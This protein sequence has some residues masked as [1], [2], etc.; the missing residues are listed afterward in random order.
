MSFKEKVQ[1]FL[2]NNLSVGRLLPIMMTLIIVWLLSMTWG[3]WTSIYSLI[4]GIFLPF[5]L[6]FALAY[7]LRPAV[8]FFERYH[9]KRPLAVMI[10][11][12]IF[13]A[14]LALLFSMIIPAL[15]DDIS[16]FINSISENI[17]I[18]YDRYVEM[19]DNPSQLVENLITQFK[20]V[21]GNLFQQLSNLPNYISGFFS[22]VFS[23][24]TTSLFSLIIG[25]Y[26]IFDY[27]RFVA[28]V[29]K[30]AHFISYKLSRSITVIDRS[31]GTYLKSLIVIMAITWVE[32]TAMYL[33][34]GHKYAFILGVLTAFSLVIPFIGP[35]II[36]VIGILTALTMPTPRLIALLVALAILS[37]LDSYVISPFVYSKRNK[38]E[39]LWSLFAFFACSS[40]FG[41]TGILLSM[42]IYFSIRSILE[43]YRNNW[44][45]PEEE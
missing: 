44:V 6:G 1:D 11:M 17:Q 23:M 2:K 41:F 5:I 21:S 4:L 15:I 13:L 24:I 42:P 37:Q 30:G 14:L 45:I 19:N 39:P 9:I 20:E 36:H 10:V 25:I 8:L 16:Q 40:L 28:S 7:V 18:L 29:H 31:V 22:S 43:L 32:Y 27:E 33:L 34:I 3:L 38:V 35:I 12:I 26:F